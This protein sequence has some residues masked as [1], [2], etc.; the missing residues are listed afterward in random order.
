MVPLCGSHKDFAMRF[1]P[2]TP[3]LLS[4]LVT[5]LGGCAATRMT[6]ETIDNANVSISHRQEAIRNPVLDSSSFV[7]EPTFYAARRPL[8]VKQIE[9]S[10]QLPASFHNQQTSVQEKGMVSLDELTSLISQ[11]SGTRVSVMQDVYDGQEGGGVSRAQQAAPQPATGAEAPTDPSAPP[12][13]PPLPVGGAAVTPGT[14]EAI[15]MSRPS[16][17]L[18]VRGF[19]YKGNLAGLLESITSR[20]NLSWRWNNNRVEIYRYETR[21]FMLNALAGT[22]N[23]SSTLSLSASSSTGGGGGGGTSGSTGQS[24]NTSVDMDIWKEVEDALKE[25][26]TEGGTYSM[27]PSAGMITVRDT[28]ASLRVVGAHI[29][30]FNRIFSRQVTI[31][32]E[33]Y[34]V[35][36]RDGDQYGVDWQAF[37]S[38]AAS[39]YGF[40]LTSGLSGQSGGAGSGNPTFTVDFTDPNSAW[41]G[42]NAMATALS[43]LG[44]TSLLTSGT[45]ISL[46]GQAVPFN[47]SR[48]KAYLAEYS[49]N[50][51]G[52]D[53]GTLTTTLT[54]DT[55]TEGFSMNFLPRVLEDNSVMLRYSV[56]LASIEGIETFET[57]DGLSAIQ[58]P[59]RA[60]RNFMQNVTI[61]SGETL[62]LTGYQQVNASKS[63]SGP[64]SGAA[65]ALGGQKNDQISTATVVITVTPYVNQSQ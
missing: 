24:V 32:V 26:L 65:W 63:S 42:S 64:L 58:L 59:Q 51:S 49:T 41:T 7:V 52:G 3:L 23:S 9:P 34:A 36:R 31:N 30:E 45:A 40:T 27:I 2:I 44:R 61:R 18:S 8:E 62:V 56:D 47:V 11:V 28:P 20:F 17:S 16:E 43:T 12:S 13:L 38:R 15:E 21:R 48:E 10:E 55:I 39:N 37:W 14:T 1:A 5:C 35:E 50:V 29:A 60:L 53:T 54:P 22:S 19:Q 33:V 57:P 46:N 4:V 25:I 6:N